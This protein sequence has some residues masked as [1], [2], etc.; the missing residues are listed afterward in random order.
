[1]KNSKKSEE[2]KIAEEKIS[3]FYAPDVRLLFSIGKS[4][5][6]KRVKAEIQTILK[7]K[8]RRTSLLR[9]FFKEFLNREAG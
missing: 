1:M 8:D 3:T 2:K 6:R 9:F 4:D 5:K 7:A